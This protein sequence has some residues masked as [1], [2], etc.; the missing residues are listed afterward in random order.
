M[1]LKEIAGMVVPLK[2]SIID[3]NLSE[4]VKARCLEYVN[5]MDEEEDSSNSKRRGWISTLLKVPFGKYSVPISADE[6]NA[7][8]CINAAR[9]CLDSVIY[10]NKVVKDTLQELVAQRV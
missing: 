1:H 5:Q 3:S 8:L 7:R 2:Y 10:G 4:L 6:L 9:D